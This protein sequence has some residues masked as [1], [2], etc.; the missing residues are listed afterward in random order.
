[1]QSQSSPGNPA[2]DTPA[3]RRATLEDVDALWQLEQVCFDS[4]RLNRRSFRRLIGSDSASILVSADRK[5]IN[6][7]ICVLYRRG[8]ALSRIY[9]L[10]LLPEARG[11]G[12]AA[13]LMN[14]AEADA[15]AHGCT[16]MRLE[17][18]PDNETA[19][20]FYKRLGYR[21]FAAVD[22][23][24]ADH[25]P[26]LRLEK[27]IRFLRITPV[28]QV[29]FYAQTTEFTCGP[30]CLLMAMSGL[31]PN[32]ALERAEELRLWREAT[33]IFMTSG[34]GGCGPHGLA[35]A[36]WR[37]GFG[38]R[39]VVN[40]QGPLFVDSVRGADKKAVMALV[41]ADLEAELAETGVIIEQGTLSAADLAACLE[42][43]ELPLVLISTWRMQGSKAPHWVIVVA[44]DEHC[45]FIHDPDVGAEDEA[46]AT[47][48]AWLPVRRDQFERMARFGRQGLRA[49]LV[50]SRAP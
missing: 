46:S 37:R 7:Y 12:L 40:Q 48:N 34:H 31:Q 25:S 26:A 22:D 8:T 36:A 1:M 44:A 15:M 35:L 5:L 3:L 27:R 30:A 50:L 47:D 18:R 21:Q 17:V 45:L 4:D 32:R 11:D 42:R 13:T 49:T 19:I 39:L 9:S 23:Y 16:H 29:P 2:A 33:T 6:G 43:G 10:A 28:R 24:Y 14:Q 38:V 20:R 41:Q